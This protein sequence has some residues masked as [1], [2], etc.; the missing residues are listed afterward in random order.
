M[1]KAFNHEVFENRMCHKLKFND[2]IS[3]RYKCIVKKSC[4]TQK[5]INRCDRLLK[6]G[7]VCWLRN[8]VGY[9]RSA[10]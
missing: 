5:Y 7:T 1:E 9:N 4:V 10:L 2:K 6:D 3:D 8:A